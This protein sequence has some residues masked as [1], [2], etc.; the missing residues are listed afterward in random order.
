MAGSADAKD[1]PVTPD[2]RYVVVRGRLWRRSNPDLSPDARASLVH[3]LMA[4]RREVGQAGRSGD[5]AALAQARAEVDRAK[6]AL[7]ERGPVWWSDGAPNLNRHM[8]HTT[9]YADW[10]ESL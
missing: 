1:Y 3:D 10:Y 7:G 9:P 2:G 8:A 6:V 5:E 4:A